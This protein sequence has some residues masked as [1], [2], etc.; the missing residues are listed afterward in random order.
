MIYYKIQIN[1]NNYFK[2]NFK[3]FKNLKII[4]KAK[5]LKQKI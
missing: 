2:C 3:T 5:L 4:T 1:E